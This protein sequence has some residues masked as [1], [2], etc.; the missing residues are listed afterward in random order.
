[1]LLDCGRM[2]PEQEE[3][4]G[5]RT[6]RARMHSKTHFVG[7]GIAGVFGFIALLIVTLALSLGA[8]VST[9]LENLP[10]YTSADA[11][12]VAEPTRVYDADGNEIVAY[13]LQN[14]RSVTLDEISDYVK[15]GTIA[16]EDKRF[17]QHSGVDPEGIARAAVG[18]IFGSGEQGGGSTITQQLVRWTVLSDEQFENSLRRKVREAFI[19]IQMEKTYTKDQILNMYLNTIFYG[20]GAYGIEAASIT[21][22]NK[23]ATDLT[24]NEAATLVGIPNSPTYY[25]PFVNYDNCKSRRNL[26]LSRMLEAGDISQEEYDTTVAEEIPLNPGELTDSTSDYPYFTDYVRD[27]LLQDFSADIINQGGLKVYT[28]IE[29]DKQKAAEEAAAETVSKIGDDGVS[30]ALVSIDNS[31]GYIVAMVGGQ[32]Y[33]YDEEA[34]QS[35]INMATSLRQAGSSFKTFTL[36]AAMR[37][38]M[39]PT[40]LLN[41]SSPMQITAEWNPHNY[42][43]N[44]YGTITLARATEL[45]SNTAYAQVIMAIGVDK[46]QETAALMGIDTPVKPVPAS[47]LGA[48]EVTPLEMC[49]AYSTIAS[50]GLHRN[51]VAISRIED[52]NGNVVYEHEDDAEQ[53][54][55]SALAQDATE[56]LEGVFRAGYTTSYVN[57]YFDADQPAAGKTGTADEA[58]DL[59]FCGFT[60]QLTTVTWVGHRSGNAPVH[61]WGSYAGTESTAQ[62][63]WT[64]YMNAVLEGV[65]RG[66][67]PTSDHEATYEPNSSWEFVGTPAYV[68]GGTGSYYTPQWSYTDDYYSDDYY[69][70][71][72]D[73]YS[74]DSYDDS[75][76]SGDDTSYVEPQ[77]P[78]TP[79]EPTTPT[80]SEEPETPSEPTTPTTPEEP[81][82]QEPPQSEQPG[83]S[84][85]PTTPDPPSGDD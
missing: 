83:T 69:S 17:Y 62:P 73:D 58:S 63:I 2:F 72:Y 24:L 57:A 23:H 55:D 28:T 15:K 74:D 22:F 60:P 3:Y 4:M 25:D 33:G 36:I 42:N 5:I 50:G 56:V 68:N 66:E 48:T 32:N 6:R 65:E 61:L 70:D 9:W 19:A 13:Y 7:F 26:V 37:E 38:G 11:F 59:W 46:L 41:C 43:N 80:T 79:S 16:T 34:G 44:Q 84:T 67:F 45:S 77:E 76:D 18:Q 49:E 27:L 21:Y 30:A 12:L 20:N 53:V 10:D 78:E 71:D 31:N 39:S 52:R 40:V 81:S 35:S 54:L 64:A 82:T 47:T 29:P 14:R 85:T 1:M 8:V 75:Y 51:P